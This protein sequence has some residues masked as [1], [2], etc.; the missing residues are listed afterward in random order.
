MT[1]DSDRKRVGPL[2]AVA[3]TT[4]DYVARTMRARIYMLLAP[5]DTKYQVAARGGRHAPALWLPLAF[6]LWVVLFVT[7]GSSAY[8]IQMH[9]T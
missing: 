7:V 8:C 9:R 2:L 4:H 5:H 6:E 1:T 3:R